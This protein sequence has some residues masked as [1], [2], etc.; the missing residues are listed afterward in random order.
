M[1]MMNIKFG[2]DTLL[3][4]PCCAAKSA[5]GSSIH[6]SID[7]LSEF[8]SAQTYSAM[9]T[10]RASVLKA[11]KSDAKFLTNRYQK[12]VSIQE[13]RD[14]GGSSTAGLYSSALRRYTG[15]F[16]SVPEFKQTVEKM[17]GAGDAPQ[18]IILSALYGPLH[19]LS[20]I[21]DY[22]L[23]MSDTPA[24]AWS[25]AFPPFLEDY[26]RRNGI[27]QVVLYVGSA[28]AYFKIA[29]KAVRALLDKGLIRRG[30]QYH[31]ENGS[32][33]TTPRQHGLRLLD[34]LDTQRSEGFARSAGIVE[35][36]L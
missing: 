10:A 21:Q 15:K 26:V 28:T 8:V 32:T 35:N 31:V 12:N 24:R 11:V 34:D 1:T 36:I 3:I 20:Q 14:I 23:M 9:L 2:A 22:N 6:S 33:P 27:N 18:L 7:P 16:Y 17:I 30:I 29:K 25:S 19:P 5:G 13:G 4:I